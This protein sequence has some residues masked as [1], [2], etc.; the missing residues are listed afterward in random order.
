MNNKSY[1]HGFPGDWKGS[2][3]KTTGAIPTEDMGRCIRLDDVVVI[4]GDL[5]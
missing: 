3:L 4:L 5:Y 1:G 2:S